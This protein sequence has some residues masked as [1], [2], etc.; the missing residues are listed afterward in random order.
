MKKG[1]FFKDIMR[2]IILMNKGKETSVY[3]EGNDQKIKGGIWVDFGI[4]IE[5]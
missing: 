5:I 2:E 4:S 1:E 3:K